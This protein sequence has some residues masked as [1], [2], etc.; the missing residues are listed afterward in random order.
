MTEVTAVSREFGRYAHK[1]A[2]SLSIAIL[3][4]LLWYINCAVGENDFSKLTSPFGAAGSV[5]VFSLENADFTH[6]GRVVSLQY[7]PNGHA[8]I[9]NE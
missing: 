4:G 9:V 5:S 3:L 2:F 7:T 8:D 1:A 6:N